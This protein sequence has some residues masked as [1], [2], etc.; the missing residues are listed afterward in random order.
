MDCRV[1]DCVHHGHEAQEFLSDRLL[2]TA[3]RSLR[4]GLLLPYH[5]SVNGETK[6]VTFFMGAEFFRK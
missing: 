4:S 2:A 3:L 6:R 1:V 5:F